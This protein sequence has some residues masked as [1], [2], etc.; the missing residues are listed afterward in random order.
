MP[1]KSYTLNT[2]GTQGVDTT[3]KFIYSNIFIRAIFIESN[4]A[5]L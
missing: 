5:I 4:Y 3:P 1:L 2:Q